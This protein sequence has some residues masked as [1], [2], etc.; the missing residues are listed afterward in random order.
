MAG[1]GAKPE[2]VDF[3]HELPLGADNGH[4]ARLWRISAMTQ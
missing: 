2:G 4:S 1:L 3:E